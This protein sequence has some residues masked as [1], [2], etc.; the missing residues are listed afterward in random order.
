ML[1]H[2]YVDTGTGTM[3][4]KRASLTP[5]RD[6]ITFEG[7]TWTFAELIGRI[8]S[9]ANVL[10]S[11]GV[12]RGDRV[13]YL[14]LNHPNFFV[15]MFATNRLGAIFVPVNFR[16]TGAELAF[17]G[18]DS[19]IHTMVADDMH[20][21]VLDAVRDDMPAGRFIGSETGGENWEVMDDLIE[22]SASLVQRSRL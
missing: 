1:D 22:A 11:G 18:T 21:G 13:G 8:D 4:A 5:K 15:T 14:G 19:G 10:A 6:A 7:E 16:L 3:M 20:H 9:F 17:I 12:G 2:N